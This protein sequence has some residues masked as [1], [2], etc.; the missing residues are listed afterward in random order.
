MTDKNKKMI[1]EN[2]QIE[3]EMKDSISL[4]AARKLIGYQRRKD[5][6]V[7]LTLHEEKVKESR[8][9]LVFNTNLDGFDEVSDLVQSIIELGVAKSKEEETQED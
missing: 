4:F 2:I 8:T 6:K 9:S 5:W 3:V 1:N 7:E